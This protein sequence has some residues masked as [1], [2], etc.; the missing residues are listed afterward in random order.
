MNGSKQSATQTSVC[1]CVP[2]SLQNTTIF[3]HPYFLCVQ[4][5]LTHCIILPQKRGKNIS[6]LTGELILA[7]FTSYLL[8]LL[9]QRMN[10]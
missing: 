4:Q 10:P 1:V 7:A 8:C 3:S 9:D 6:L 5:K 2:E